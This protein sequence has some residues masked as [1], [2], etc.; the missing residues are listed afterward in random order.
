MHTI[1]LSK[2]LAKLGKILGILDPCLFR[3]IT[4][5]K[6]HKRPGE[7]VLKSMHRK[8]EE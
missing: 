7:T 8:L 3:Q 1:K 2:S 4:Q 5:N 6:I